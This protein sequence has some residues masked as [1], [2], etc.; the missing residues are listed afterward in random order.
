MLAVTNP[1]GFVDGDPCPRL[2]CGVVNILVSSYLFFKLRKFFLIPRALV[3]GSAMSGELAYGT[4]EE[5]G[6]ADCAMFCFVVFGTPC[7]R[8]VR[9]FAILCLVP[10]P[11]LTL[12]APGDVECRFLSCDVFAVNGDAITNKFVGYVDVSATN[13]GMR[14]CLVILPVGGVFEPTSV[15]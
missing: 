3:A 4:F 10:S 1:G 2:V 13:L 12:G 7:T 8:V 6:A 14:V 5:G 15:A 9:G 11:L